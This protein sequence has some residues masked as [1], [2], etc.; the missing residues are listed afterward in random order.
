MTHE[1][2]S[3][4][5]HDRMNTIKS[6]AISRGNQISTYYANTGQ[7]DLDG[8]LIYET[9]K[10]NEESSKEK[11]SESETSEN[12]DHQANKQTDLQQVDMDRLK[13]AKQAALNTIK[14]KN[15]LTNHL[16]GEGTLFRSPPKCED[17]RA[18]CH[19][20]LKAARLSTTAE[21]TLQEMEEIFRKIS[22]LMTQFSSLAA[23]SGVN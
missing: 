11:E 13:S 3:C 7:E 5:K 12:H 4:N 14:N 2:T 21:T 19:G 15:N 20:C 8:Y 9:K 17:C 23:T 18:N 10:E 22:C 16:L 6:V 1:S